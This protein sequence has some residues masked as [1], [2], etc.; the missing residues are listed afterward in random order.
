MA[1]DYSL[2]IRIHS[3]QMTLA[4]RQGINYKDWFRSFLHNGPPHSKV[5]ESPG[6]FLKDSKDD[7]Y[8]VDLEL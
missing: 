5:I 2:Q 6:L 1:V 3:H 8:A 7:L 4:F